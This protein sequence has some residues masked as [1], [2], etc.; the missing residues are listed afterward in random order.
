MSF[1]PVN[2]LS[3]Y[4]C[5]MGNFKKEWHAFF[6]EMMDNLAELGKLLYGNRVSIYH[7]DL[8]LGSTTSFSG[9]KSIMD[10]TLV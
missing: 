2:V 7:R 5:M 3:F 4:F 9:M 10:D 8:F 6:L 1:G